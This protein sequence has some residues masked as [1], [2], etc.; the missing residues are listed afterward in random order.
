MSYKVFNHF[1]ECC[2]GYATKLKNEDIAVDWKRA[3]MKQYI[4]LYINEHKVN[5]KL[6]KYNS[7]NTFVSELVA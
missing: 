6:D 2:K 4:L 5:I 1:M 7:F 3:F